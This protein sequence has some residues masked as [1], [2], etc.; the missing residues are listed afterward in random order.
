MGGVLW[1]V[2]INFCQ[3]IFYFVDF[4]NLMKKIIEKMFELRWEKNGRR[5]FRCVVIVDSRLL[6]IYMM[7]IVSFRFEFYYG[8][9]I[10]GDLMDLP[11]HGIYDREKERERER[12][13]KTKFKN[14]QTSFS[15]N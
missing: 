9:Y 7:Y 8:K 14:K 13:Y 6:F 15:L 5:Y 4:V 12:C 2:H 11:L 10:Q 1:S 3:S